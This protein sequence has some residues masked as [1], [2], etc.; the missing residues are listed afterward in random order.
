MGPIVWQ[1]SFQDMN[2]DFVFSRCALMEDFLEG[3]GSVNSEEKISSSN[4]I[5]YSSHFS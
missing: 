4:I 1:I 3:Y 2:G 5:F